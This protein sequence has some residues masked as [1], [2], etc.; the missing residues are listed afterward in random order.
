MV[1]IDAEFRCTVQCSNGTENTL[2]HVTKMDSGVLCR[3]NPH[4]IYFQRCHILT[5]QVFLFYFLIPTFTSRQLPV[6]YAMMCLLR[7]RQHHGAA[8]TVVHLK[9]GSSRL[10][11][12]SALCSVIQ[13]QSSHI[14]HYYKLQALFC[15][16]CCA[17]LCDSRGCGNLSKYPGCT[18]KNICIY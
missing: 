5:T 18:R 3:R 8:L 13:N 17:A 12:L 9:Q 10:P 11:L 4:I 16:L 15:L 2:S 14:Q 6:W 7:H 1:R